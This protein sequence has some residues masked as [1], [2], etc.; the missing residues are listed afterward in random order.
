MTN[1]LVPAT[2]AVAL[3]FVKE[4]EAEGVR[5]RSPWTD[6]GPTSVTWAVLSSV[7]LPLTFTA[8]DTSRTT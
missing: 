5:V 4:R 1:V 7:R 8:T 6:S 2:V 3:E